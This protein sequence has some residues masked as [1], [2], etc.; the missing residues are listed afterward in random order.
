LGVLWGGLARFRKD[1]MTNIAAAVAY[2]AFLAL[3]ASLLIVLGAFSL[4]AGPHAVGEVVSKLHGVVPGQAISLLGGSLL[5]ATRDKGTGVTVLV[6]GTALALWT[7]TSAMESLMWAFNIAFERNDTRHFLHRRLTA[8]GMVAFALLGFVLAFGVLVL[9][10]HLSSWVGNAVG[11]R[12][13]VKIAW[14]TAEWPLVAAGLLFTFAGLVYLGPDGP[15]PGWRSL[16][17]GSVVAVAIGLAGSGGFALY[18]GSFASYNK[19]WGSLAAVAITLT[20]L[21]LSSCALLL[22]AEIDAEAARR[23][24]A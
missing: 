1:H 4:L 15:K 17:L 11:A 16:T 7:S 6:T 10:S 22:G 18:A 14:Y 2:H 5:D 19:T 13:L 21:W 8:L 9:G 23:R 12:T 3:P 20:W 24:A